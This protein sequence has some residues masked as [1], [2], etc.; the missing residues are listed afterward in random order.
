VVKLD[1]KFLRERSWLQLLL[2][3]CLVV[4][5]LLVIFGLSS[6]LPIQWASGLT[7]VALVITPGYLLAD[8]IAGRLN[9]DRLERLALAFPL[10][11]TVLAVPGM[12]SLVFHL[13]IQHLALGW[14]LASATVIGSWVAHTIFNL[15][16]GSLRV[17]GDPWALDEIL[18]LV[19]VLGAFLASIPALTLNKIDG[20]AYA[21]ASFAADALAGLPLNAVEPLFGTSLGPG[22]RMVFNQTL[23]LTYLWSYLSGVDPITLSATASRAILALWG[24]LASYTLGKAAGGNSRRFGLVVVSVQMLIFLAAPFLRGDNVGLFFFERTNADKFLVPLT[25]LPV[26]FAMAIRFVRHGKR[27]A[28]GL[29]AL[30]TVAVSA[31]HPLVAAMLAL[32][33]A[34]FAGVHLLVGLRRWPAWKNA[35]ALGSLIVI[36]MALPLVQLVISRGEDSLASSFPSTVQ[37]W[38]LGQKMVPA[39]PYLYLPSLDY[40]GTPP[41]LSQ[42]DATQVD[43]STN[44]F[45]MWRVAVNLNRRRLLLF[46]LDQ[47]I[48]DPNLIVEPPYL[49]ALLLLPLLLWRLRLNVGAQFAIGS[50]LAILL[51]LFNPILT[52]LVGSLVMP[53]ILWRFIWIL[54]Y[55]LIIAMVIYRIIGATIRLAARPLR[56]PDQLAGS[57]SEHLLTGIVTL[58]FVITAALALSPAIARNF[59]NLED[60]TTSPYYFPVPPDILAYLSE[61]TQDQPAM[62][63]ADQDLSVTIPAYVA[64]A[65]VLAHRMPT[66]SEVFPADGQDIALQRLVD[67][68]LFF[69][70]PY[71]TA[72]SLDILQRY[73][74][75]FVITKSGSDLDTQLRLVPGWFQWIVDD[76]SFSLYAVQ[77]IPE[78]TPA[79]S[80]NTAMVQRDWE[81]AEQLYQAA[82]AASPTDLLALLGLA[83]IAHAHG[84]FD[85][86]LVQLQEA[87][88]Q[89]GL[90]NL[91]YRLGQLYVEQGQLEEAIAQFDQAQSLAPRVARFHEALGDACLTAGDAACAAEQYRAAA[92][93][94]DLPD[95]DSQLIAEADLWRQRGRVDEALPHYEAA[96]ATRPSV[97]NQ[98]MLFGAYREA[99]EFDRARTLIQQLRVQHPL[100][101][102]IVATWADLEAVQGKTDVAERLFQ[103]AIWLQDIQGQEAVETRLDLAQMLAETGRMDDAYEQ[104]SEALVREPF[105]AV[106][107]GILGDL[108]HK[109]RQTQQAIAAYRRAFEL[110]PTRVDSY[111]ALRNQLRQN[112]GQPELL[113]N[114]LEEAIQLN[115]G[116]TSLLLDLGDQ[117]QR[118]G[119]PQAALDTYWS[120]LE[121]LDDLELS[122]R[123]RPTALAQSRS[124]V[125]ARLAALYEDL[126][127]IDSAM[128]FHQAAVAAAPEASWPQVLLGDALRRRNDYEGAESLYLSVVQ[129]YP[130]YVDGYVRLA[131]LLHTR[132]R[133]QEAERLRDLIPQIALAQLQDPQRAEANLGRQY[134]QVALPV[135][136]GQLHSDETLVSLEE[137]VSNLTD[138]REIVNQALALEENA[139]AIRALAGV[140]QS[141]NQLDEAIVLYEER[142]LAGEQESWEPVLLARY[143]NDL[144]DLY[145]SQRRLER[146]RQA[147]EEAVALDAWWPEARLGLA[148][149]AAV[150]GDITSS[151][152]N[153]RQAVEMAPGA[154]EAQLVLANI[155]DQKGDDL[156]A[157]AI[158]EATAEAHPGD[159]EATLA[160][161]RALQLRNRQ[162]EAERA[163]RQTIALNPGVA[164]AYTGLAELLIDLGRFEEAQDL[165]QQAIQ[166]DQHDVTAL[167][168]LGDLEQR[169][170]NLNQA[171][172]WYDRAAE[173]ARAGNP[174]NT[175]LLVSLLQYGRYEQA[176]SFV[177]AILGEQPDDSEMLLYL[178]T[179]QRLLG[180][181]E[182]AEAALNKAA[183]ADDLDSRPYAE[184]AALRVAEGRPREALPH[185][186]DAITRSPDEASYY[187]SFSEL[188]VSQGLLAEAINHLAQGQSRVLQSDL[189]AVAIHDLYMLQGDVDQARATLQ[190]AIQDS[191][192]TSQ[193][194]LALGAHYEAVGEPQEAEAQYR[195][196]LAAYPDDARTH[197]ALG[198]LALNQ[199]RSG[200]ALLHYG[201]ATVID[202]ADPQPFLAIARVYEA[203]GNTEEAMQ[204]YQHALAFEPTQVDASVNLAALYQAEERWDEA[205]AVY[206]RGLEVVPNSPELV[207]ALA[208][209]LAQTDRSAEARA[210]LD[211]AVE[212]SPTAAHLV[213]RASYQVDRG[214]L[215]AALIDLEEA[216]R[217]QPGS[218]DALLVLGQVKLE[219]RKYEEAREAFQSI[220]SLAPGLPVGY[221]Q[222]GRLANKLGDRDAAAELARAAREAALGS[223]PTPYE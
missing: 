62:V 138:G 14:I 188:L 175:T 192:N 191:G 42:V 129:Q 144:G 169:N 222:L 71:L 164:G 106:A 28:W 57:S 13:T 47:Y 186:R 153:V 16:R 145:L 185:H 77:Q 161:A 88:G 21:V 113:R 65:H 189:L 63:L 43:S 11:I 24:L 8:M 181:F 17:Q 125:Y 67:Q 32:G 72:S 112:G 221:I 110:D 70:T 105:N 173:L 134:A 170:G 146:A 40:Y 1:R 149:V 55:A 212:R 180:Q 33:L 193:L 205:Q 114:L 195:Q 159:A 215:D 93:S 95:V 80:G 3:Y 46:N 41:Q 166:I 7:F 201:R 136:D 92:H 171:T 213:A 79:I 5:W 50:S 200:L 194:L 126:G 75:Q 29:A 203:A 135:V 220:V 91:H 99:G 10:G 165:L 25:M 83:D 167:I 74:V 216:L 98:L 137:R 53:W 176:L 118:L 12:I 147:Y 211:Q 177:T 31:I 128:N 100:D 69:R 64:G 148:E 27:R 132:G 184:L 124:F 214:D 179:I 172:S 133:T 66:T 155:L 82:L 217:S 35:L 19:L 94:D 101:A 9:L 59:Q 127:Q 111:L 76:Q 51:I 78:V 141:R 20:D 23:P 4:L 58:G 162:Q 151:L 116:N 152:Q 157:M 107:Y 168:R 209:L 198:D 36:V 174:S 108:Y 208:D 142:I 219:Q 85:K 39:F 48:S 37:D 52:P 210:L 121:A 131:D 18:L 96:V 122:E 163:Y 68:D 143:Y 202:P 61:V 117:L 123:L 178:G 15:R 160:L 103:Y 196:A 183:A 54:P 6:S 190:Q 204:A 30:S 84:Q 156:E 73:D 34:G 218:L 2:A 206:E 81:R 199:D 207:A 89:A 158:Y 223:L 26:V 44:P 120:V 22:V 86:A 45:L 182:A 102:E 38:P 197:L 154:V 140:Y 104:V 150:Q 90:P 139:D 97:Y 119:E 87:I 115:P 60:R 56:I 109:Q 49:L 187:L 130:E